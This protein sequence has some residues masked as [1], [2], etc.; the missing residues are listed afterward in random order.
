MKNIKYIYLYSLFCTF[1]FSNNHIA[2][3]YF[4]E[5]DCYVKNDRTD[6]YSM[7]VMTGQ[8]IFN[9]DIIKT[10][11]KSNCFIRLLDDKTHI[12][13]GPNSIVQIDVSLISQ[14]INLLKGSVYV[15][16]LYKE[17]IKT[18]IFT[19]F[20]QIYLNNH[21]FWISHFPNEKDMMFSLDNS[22]NVYN[23]LLK[24]K[25]VVPMQSLINVSNSISFIENIQAF[26]P[27]Y[28]VSDIGTFDY[29]MK[30][31]EL[32]SFDMIPV[33]GERIILKEIIDP[34]SMSFS[35]GPYF[36]NNDTHFKIG[37]YP[38]YMYKNLLFNFK[39][40]SYANP[41]GTNF[42]NDW[43]DF[44]DILE[45][46]SVEYSFSDKV[47]KI[48]LKYGTIDNVTFGAGYMVND[49]SNSL[50]YPRQRNTGFL[51]DYIFDVDFVDLKIIIPSV[52]DFNESGGVIGA[53]SSL[54]VSHNFPLT[55][56]VGFITDLNQSSFLSH[57]LEKKGKSR[58]V[59]G[60]EFDYNY[61]LISSIDL[62]LDMFGEIVG[63][64]YPEYNYYV[65]RD[66]TDV[67]DDLKWRKGAWGINAPGISLKFDNRYL[68][69]FSLNF[70]SATFIPNY[71]NSTYL[72]NRSRYYKADL[73]FPLV[74]RQIDYL[75]DNFLIGCDSEAEDA[76]CEYI[77]PKDVYPI[78]FENNGFSP[79]ATYGFTTE[80]AYNIQTY[81]NTSFATSV[82][83]EN[84]NESD[85]YCSIQ[86]ALNI[87]DGFIRN[88]KYLKFYYSNLFFEKLSDKYRMSFGM[89]TEIYLPSRLSLIIN[90]GQVY[91]DSK[92]DIIDDNNIDKMINSMIN[93]KYEF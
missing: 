13:I 67:S 77:I 57:Y 73:D 17:N 90:L 54:F 30:K 12:H 52:R 37:L 11:D 9:N 23:N 35:S 33:Y 43:D 87:N 70:N 16:N 25:I 7:G 80:F 75:N 59:Y 55:L 76:E 41:S 74:Q 45:K 81:I 62:E 1:V 32:K 39:L 29:N 6:G 26:V 69:K 79:Y 61:S 31:I 15:K 18:Y 5:G 88:V 89:E 82:F 10:N 64:W 27:D 92:N 22:I 14:E 21:R 8:N 93:L 3:V 40:E 60:L 91:Y 42:S 86:T 49:L 20:N 2:S 83:V 36:I 63:L 24:K 19:S 51:L 56:G 47:K 50:D 85:V 34:W 28:I 65:L 71:F 53:R 4:V 44:I 66:D 58:S 46:I 84:S 78:L 38:Q 68:F 48:D 72:Y